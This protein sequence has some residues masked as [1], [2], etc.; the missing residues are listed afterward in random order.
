ML[1]GTR[2]RLPSGALQ[3]RAWVSV[4][5]RRKRTA[6]GHRSWVEPRRRLRQAPRHPRAPPYCS[7]AT[8]AARWASCSR[9]R[10][11]D[12]RRRTRLTP[13][14]CRTAPLVTDG[15]PG[16]RGE[17]VETVHAVRDHLTL[18][19]EGRAAARMDR[20]LGRAAGS[21]HER[22]YGPKAKPLRAIRRG[23]FVR[24]N[25]LARQDSNLE[26][27]DPESGA[28]P[29]SHA[30]AAGRHDTPR[31]PDPGYARAIASIGDV[32]ERCVAVRPAA[33]A[34]RGHIWPGDPSFS[35]C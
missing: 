30:P 26:P 34:N 1:P 20:I 9:S 14:S 17:S 22:R 3:G 27:P 13:A 15:S 25:W 2:P 21:R 29:L 23:S 18:A 12:T 19:M 11:V 4:V 33:G 6:P 10:R 35:P 5:A 32:G 7:R 8:P 24:G 31:G 16:M 28:L